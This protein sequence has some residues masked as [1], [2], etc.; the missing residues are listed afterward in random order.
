MGYE[1]LATPGKVG[2]RTKF[3]IIKGTCRHGADSTALASLFI[4]RPPRD[5]PNMTPARLLPP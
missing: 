4:T 2:M 5:G 3:T 1:K